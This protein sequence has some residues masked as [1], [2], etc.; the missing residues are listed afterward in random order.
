[1]SHDDRIVVLRGDGQNEIVPSMPRRQVCSV[2][3]GWPVME[4]SSRD[5]VNFTCHYLRWSR[6]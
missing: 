2:C 4:E 1:M 3:H 5:K 6:N